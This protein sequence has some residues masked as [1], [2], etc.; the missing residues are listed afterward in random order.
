MRRLTPFIEIVCLIALIGCHKDRA[1]LPGN[2]APPATGPVSSP[3]PEMNDESAVGNGGGV[4]VS[5]LHHTIANGLLASLEKPENRG[6]L[7]PGERTAIRGYIAKHEVLLRPV[8]PVEAARKHTTDPLGK[9]SIT[10]DGRLIHNGQP[11]NQRVVFD[12]GIRRWVIQV[13]EEAWN[14]VISLSG[15]E[16]SVPE[17]HFPELL[18]V[19]LQYYHAL[20]VIDRNGEGPQALSAGAATAAKEDNRPRRRDVLP[21]AGS[22]FRGEVSCISASILYEIVAPE[23]RNAADRCRASVQFRRNGEVAIFLQKVRVIDEDFASSYTYR[24]V[25]N[26]IAVTLKDGV[27]ERTFELWGYGNDDVLSL[28]PND[29]LYRTSSDAPDFGGKTFEETLF[30]ELARNGGIFG[31][32]KWAPRLT[33]N[34]TSKEKCLVRLSLGRDRSLEV[35]LTPPGKPTEHRRGTYRQIGYNLLLQ[36][37]NQVEQGYLWICRHCQKHLFL[38]VGETLW[39]ELDDPHEKTD[40]RFSGVYNHS[41]RP[42]KCGQIFPPYSADPAICELIIRAQPYDESTRSAEGADGTAQI[43]VRRL[44][45]TPEKHVRWFIGN[46]WEAGDTVHIELINKKQGITLKNT[47]VGL[48]NPEFYLVAEGEVDDECT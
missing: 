36:Y 35:A 39:G 34:L 37:P 10:R 33:Q 30:C 44:T 14:T 11:V 47:G 20:K 18:A 42:I 48:A 25:Q 15:D 21:V 26:H 41:N 46:F 9:Q 31:P 16:G 40:G 43:G 29:H 38:P 17:E 22:E 27:L 45:P 32:A 3:V 2:P 12:H 7:T 24:Y 13:D 1:L 6:L 4:L 28:T 8:N 19:V 5:L 23:T